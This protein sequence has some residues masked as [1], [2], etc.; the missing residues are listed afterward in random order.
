MR[1]RTAPSDIEASAT[2]GGRFILLFFRVI[3]WLPLPVLYFLAD[4][5]YLLAYYVFRVNRKVTLTNLRNSFP[6]LS[7][8][9]IDKLAARSSRNFLTVAV[10]TGKMMSMTPNV[11]RRHVHTQNLEVVTSHLDNGQSVILL[12]GH[13]C[14]WEW[15]ILSLCTYMTAPVDV[16]YKPM[17]I[18]AFDYA[19]LKM[20]A[21]LGATMMSS[22]GEIGAL[23]K[24]EKAVR[25]I[26]I[27]GDQAPG[28]SERK[29]WAR[30]L[31]QD[32]AFYPAIQRIARL[33]RYPVF[34]VEMRR[35]KRGLYELDFKQI[36]YPPYDRGTQVLDRFI[37]V[38]EAYIRRY[39]EDWLWA[40]RR[41]KYGRDVDET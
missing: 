17:K 41:W 40:Y 22:Q 8:A 36:G 26:G 35:I 27:A 18:D 7:E 38:L 39:P 15:I 37:Q 20:R 10:E 28:R 2:L 9:A 25:V 5:L 24:S 19:F 3:S 29:H 16:L 23:I 13:Q 11:V 32:T 31:N 6:E 4:G 21:R 34:F 14:N 1:S 33:T 12:S 30:F